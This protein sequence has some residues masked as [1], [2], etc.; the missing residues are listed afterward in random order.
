MGRGERVAFVDC[1]L[2]GREEEEP[3]PGRPPNERRRY[4]GMEMGA[5]ARAGRARRRHCRESGNYAAAAASCMM[6]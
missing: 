6:C 3:I 1:L 2:V 5:M 4:R